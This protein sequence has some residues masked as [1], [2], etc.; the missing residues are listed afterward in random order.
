MSNSKTGTDRD[1]LMALEALLR[2]RSDTATES[3]ADAGQ[4][5]CRT[6]V[7]SLPPRPSSATPGQFRLPAA[8]AA[9][10]VSFSPHANVNFFPRASPVG[11]LPLEP[12]SFVSS[13]SSPLVPMSPAVLT[14]A[15]AMASPPPAVS[16]RPGKSPAKPKGKRV[17]RQNEVEAALKSKPQR[18]RKRDNLN[19]MERL[20]LTR[21]RNREHA[22]ST[23][24][25]KKAR[26]QELLDS[27]QKFMALR[28]AQGLTSRRQECLVK[29]L[30]ILESTLRVEPNGRHS[31]VS[32]DENDT[33]GKSVTF[34]QPQQ[35]HSFEAPQETNGGDI[36][37]PDV[38]ANMATFRFETKGNSRLCMPGEE[39][40]SA[41]ANASVQ[42]FGQK[43]VA[44]ATERYGDKAVE[45][46]CFSLQDPTG[47]LAMN[48]ADSGFA[49]VEIRLYNAQRTRSIVL[50]SAVLKCQFTSGSDKLQSVQWCMLQDNFDQILEEDNSS[51][52]SSESLGIQQ[53][54]PSVVSLDPVA[55][56]EAAADIDCGKTANRASVEATEGG[57]G[58]NF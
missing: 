29:L 47:G 26:Y 42:R 50:M 46:I 30:S 51:S 57:P 15:V 8:A 6:P 24:V 36:T 7:A 3:S 43:L 18:G 23:R 1:S 13:R 22:K 5:T 4:R 10:Q 2:I 16:R 37:L 20:E 45:R 40:L 33:S 49:D 9:A 25:R 11:F 31:A 28:E 48:K 34:S 54:Y 17:I 44:A 58:I 39:T 12:A 27:E 19:A 56:G 38:V 52:S 41:S 55:N 35:E 14:R 21:T 53:S 32:T